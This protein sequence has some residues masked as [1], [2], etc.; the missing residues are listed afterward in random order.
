M[1]DLDAAIEKLRA[2]GATPEAIEKFASE[3]ARKRDNPHTY[4]SAFV[5]DSTCGLICRLCGVSLPSGSHSGR[6]L[7]DHPA[8]IHVA[9][10]NAQH[11]AGV[12]AHG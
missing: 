1:S 12:T 2:S 7:G 4:S 8:N 11:R 10:H 9:W 5:P 3:T 6:Y